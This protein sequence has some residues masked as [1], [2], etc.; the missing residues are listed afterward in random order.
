MHA[1]S[2]TVP[3]NRSQATFVFVPVRSLH[4]PLISSLRERYTT[5]TAYTSETVESFTTLASLTACNEDRW[6]M[7]LSRISRE[8]VAYGFDMRRRSSI[9]AKWWNGH[10]H[11]WA[12]AAIGC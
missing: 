11:G 3:S 9:T 8:A 1:A 12:N 2:H 10:A 7:F 5:I 4:S 6:K